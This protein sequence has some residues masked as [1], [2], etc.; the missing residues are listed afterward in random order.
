MS[1]IP[2]PIDTSDITLNEELLALCEKLAEN[3]HDVWAKGRADSGWV[4][5]PERND[6]KKE[7]P[8]MVPYGE[9]PESEKEYDRNASME[10]LKLIVKLGYQI[11]KK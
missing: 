9:L 10:T 11:E 4:Y 5:G 8:C 1:Y 6:Q 3:C 7:N 2:N